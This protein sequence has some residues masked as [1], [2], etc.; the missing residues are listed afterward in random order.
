MMKKSKIRMNIPL[1]VVAVCVLAAFSWSF[2]TS[3]LS[4]QEQLL[5]ENRGF[6]EAKG[7]KG[8]WLRQDGGYVILIEDI[9]PEGNLKVFY[10]NP[11]EI[12]VS[13]AN[14]KYEDNRI[15][16]FIELRDVN[17]PGSTYKLLYTTEQNVLIG[18]YFQAVH[19]Q[20]FN[21]RFKRMT[22]Q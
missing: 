9:K 5:P 14:W 21:V 1:I 20:T 3:A 4:G 2:I 12:N 19:K 10:F 13:R 7:I 17:Y 8:R 11:R 16:I 18:T 22:D 15:H 6:S